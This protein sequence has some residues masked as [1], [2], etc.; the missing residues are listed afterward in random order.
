[1][2]KHPIYITGNKNKVAY[3]K[4]VLGFE[5]EHHELDLDE[6]Q[7]VDPREVIEHKVK[8]AYALL[9][10]P[11]LVE[12]TSLFFNALDSLP[13]PF[14]KFFV[15]AKNG[16]E[17]MCRMLDGFDDR[18]A[19]VTASYGYYDGK[20]MHIFTGRLDGTI[21]VSPRGDGGYGSD[22]IFEPEGYGGLT[23]AELPADK[24]LET[25]M[26]IRDYPGLKAFLLQ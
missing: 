12:D 7:S 10:Q 18:S 16:K 13:G 8:Q 5:L 19:Y 1:M 4:K 2:S 6:I 22:A 20:E 25:Y 11:V 14:V 15:T 23:R 3:L 26:K 24:D 21:A 17:M 9:Q